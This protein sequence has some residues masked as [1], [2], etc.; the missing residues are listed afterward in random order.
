[1]LF[2][3]LLACASEA[4]PPARVQVVTGTA[5]GAHAD[6]A[7]AQKGLAALGVALLNPE[8]S[9]DPANSGLREKMGGLSGSDLKGIRATLA[10]LGDEAIAFARAHRGGQT[11]VA[12]A[13]CP[14]APGRWLQTGAPLANPYYG[15]SMLRCGVFEK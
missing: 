11:S 1:M 3:L 5:T 9:E 4:P 12:V 15:A 7:G 6:P 14:M 8:L 2:V 10:P 13:F